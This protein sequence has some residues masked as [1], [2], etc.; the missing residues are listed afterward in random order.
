MSLVQ[1]KLFARDTTIESFRDNRSSYSIPSETVVGE[2][3]LLSV[4]Y[5]LSGSSTESLNTKP[6]IISK[7]RNRLSRKQQRLVD[8]SVNEYSRMGDKK[9]SSMYISGSEKVD[10]SNSASYLSISERSEAGNDNIDRSV[11]SFGSSSFNQRVKSFFARLKPGSKRS[12]DSTTEGN[13]LHDPEGSFSLVPYRSNL[14]HKLE[15]LVKSDAIQRY[16][17]FY[18]TRSCPLHLPDP[19]QFLKAT[20]LL[21]HG[22]LMQE[23]GQHESAIVNVLMA[24]ELGVPL[25]MYWLAI[26]SRYGWSRSPNREESFAC[27]LFAA[28]LSVLACIQQENQE[29]PAH[30]ISIGQMMNDSIKRVIMNSAKASTFGHRRSST[31]NKDVE[32][33]RGRPPI[34]DHPSTPKIE[35]ES[36]NADAQ[37]SPESTSSGQFNSSLR[38]STLPLHRHHRSDTHTTPPRPQKP[39]KSPLSSQLPSKNFQLSLFDSQ[40]LAL[41]LFEIGAC[42]EYGLGTKK[43]YSEAAY[44]YEL[45]AGLGDADAAQQIADCYRHGHGVPRDKWRAAAYYRLAEQRGLTLINCT[46]IHK[47]KWGGSLKRSASKER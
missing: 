20:G 4:R 13:F 12:V 31:M 42:Y 38:S 6:S 9:A 44:Y 41:I 27:F 32:P 5:S 19:E 26:S 10:R 39:Q 23:K 28:Y 37:S 33:I 15:L 3:S 17:P 16:M 46:W 14:L 34:S 1:E 29:Q 24:A 11:R 35:V 36:F 43:D 47:E 22:L 45:A 18:D 40:E 30:V 2:S 8:N 25:A 21:Q 7:L